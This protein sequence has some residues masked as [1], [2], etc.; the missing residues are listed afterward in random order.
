MELRGE[1]GAVGWDGAVAKNN[2]PNCNSHGA[3]RAR[4]TEREVA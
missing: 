4:G 2:S 3:N 1:G